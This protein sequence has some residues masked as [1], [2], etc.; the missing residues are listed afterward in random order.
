MC[1]IQLEAATYS[2]RVGTL[3]L[4]SPDEESKPHC[5]A[6]SLELD[7]QVTG[8]EISALPKARENTWSLCRR[9]CLPPAPCC[10]PL[11][12]SREVACCWITGDLGG[13]F[14]EVSQPQQFTGTFGMPTSPH[15]G[16]W[17]QC[18]VRW[19]QAVS[20]TC[21]SVTTTKSSAIKLGITVGLGAYYQAL[22]YGRA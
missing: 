8:H 19:L 22:V 16:C 21:T 14:V 18:P 10:F 13:L 5:R 20:H 11:P 3:L 2:P 1:I 15:H 6:V 7:S 9:C 17:E 4:A 12:W